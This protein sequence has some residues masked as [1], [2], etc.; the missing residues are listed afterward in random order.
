ME[1]AEKHRRILLY[2]ENYR[3]LRTTKTIKSR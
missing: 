1:N 2:V 3:P